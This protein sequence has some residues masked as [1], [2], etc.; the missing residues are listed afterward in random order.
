VVITG[1]GLLTALG[2]GAAPTWEAL[3]AGKSGIDRIRAYDPG[4]LRTRIGAELAGFDPK[5]YAD[6]RAL[7]NMTG[8]DELAMAGAVLALRDAG[9][10]DTGLS[11]V[12]G[13]RAGLFLGGNKS[14]CR[15]EEVVAGAT[16]AAGADG[17]ADHRRLG[18]HAASALSPLFYVQG[19]Q[20]AALFHISA[21]YGFRGAN[22]YYAGTAESGATAIG[23]GFR[24]VRRGETDL[25]LAGGWDD[26]ASWWPMSEMDTLGVLTGRN[27]LGAEAFRPYDRDRSGSV[28]G[29]GAAFVVLESYESA[30]ARGAEVY[31]EVLGAGHGNDGAA[32][33]TPEPTGRGLARAIRAALA[34]AALSDVDYIAAHGCGT[35]LGDRSETAAIRAALGPAADRVWASSV[36][37]QTGHLVGGAGALNVA[38]AALA[39]RHRT[40]PPTLHLRHPGEGCDLDY[41]PGQARPAPLGTALALARG[42][43]GQQV[44]VA[45]GRC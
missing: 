23:R 44:A 21:A 42:I 14:M 40:A 33:L 3:L 9:V 39:L 7:R 27:D 26:P 37:P 8:N 18:E 32:V 16:V 28:L 41:V 22:A 38:V 35:V 31:A 29:N 5:R 1:V 34:D 45:L 17:V 25:V 15:P 24:S 11:E 30:A 10:P 6:R 13:P 12:D 36:K 2:E 20:A 43:A 19:L 4:G